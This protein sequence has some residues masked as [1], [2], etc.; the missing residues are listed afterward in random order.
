MNCD[1]VAVLEGWERSKGAKIE[2][3]LAKDLGMDIV[4]AWTLQAIK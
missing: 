2:V 4:D 1:T 3:D